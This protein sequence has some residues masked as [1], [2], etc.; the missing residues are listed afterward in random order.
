LVGCRLTAFRRAWRFF[1]YSALIAIADHVTWSTVP[2]KSLGDL[3]RDSLRRRGW[4]DVDPDEISV[5]NPYNHEAVKSILKPMVGT[6]NKSM[7]PMSGAGFRKK[8][9]HPLGW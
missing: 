9:F 4:C 5:I 2:R 3:A 1:Q 8:V 6:T 7:A